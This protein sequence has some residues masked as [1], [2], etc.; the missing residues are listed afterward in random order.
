MTA[1]T[2]LA[3]WIEAGMQILPSRLGHEEGQGAIEYA[4]VVAVVVTVVI[5]V[6][7][8]TATGTLGTAMS[9]ALGYVTNAISGI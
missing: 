5:A 8:T 1:L 3:T 2:V 9:A 4:I 6:L 7:G